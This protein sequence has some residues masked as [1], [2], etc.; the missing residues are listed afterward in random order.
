MK[1]LIGLLLVV[2]LIGFGCQTDDHSGHNHAPDPHEGHDHGDA[3]EII[4]YTIWEAGF[5]LFL[6]FKPL[7]AG[8]RTILRTVITNLN[9]FTA[10]NGALNVH[11]K[12]KSKSKAKKKGKGIFETKLTIK[13]TGKYDLVF[14]LDDNGSKKSIVLSQL[15][16][17]KDDHDIFHISYP[18]SDEQGSI[19][20]QRKQAWMQNFASEKAML[21]PIGDIIHTSG[22]IEPSTADLSSIVAKCDGVVAIRKKNMTSGSAVRRGELLFSVTGK[23][24][25]KDDLEMNFLKAK[26]NLDR[27][28]SSLDRKKTLL[29]DNIIGQ[30]EYDQVLNQYELA[31][32]EYNNIKKLYTKGEKRHLVTNSSSGFVSQ[33]FIQEGQFVKA[34]Q[35]LAS[36]LKTKRVQ[37][38]LDISPRYRSMLP[39][40]INANFINPYND[41]AY[42]LSELDGKIISFGRMTSHEEGHYIPM[43]FEINNHPDLS[44]GALIEAYLMTQPKQEQLTIP[45]SAVLEEM[46]SYVVFI[47]KSAETFE[48][49]VVEVGA[50]DGKFMQI[51]SGLSIGDKVVTKGALQVKLAS[52]SG[53][54]DPHAG[55]TH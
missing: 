35:Q 20:Y 55:H 7:V 12:G 43:Y 13:K 18:G 47:Q 34:G 10:F 32:A 17:A 30:K 50:N 15:P 6:E 5:E 3:E 38:K 48:K 14:I 53:T 45:I 19:S 39:S 37:V 41:K 49:Q 54:V 44:P 42:P 31:E 40:V 33:L 36:I 21:R 23:G 51:L 2:C 22:I 1:I 24:I 9:D 29:D 52:M 8:E 27:Q 28:K 46:G 4:S 11:V 26:S 16:V 25:V